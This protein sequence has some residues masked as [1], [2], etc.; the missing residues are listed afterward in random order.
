[1]NGRYEIESDAD[2]Y[3]A[4]YEKREQERR[5]VA[6]FYWGSDVEQWVRLMAAEE[7]LL[8][9]CRDVRLD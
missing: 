1:M 5:K 3:W 4:V 6:S 7:N 9:G 2:G 8:S